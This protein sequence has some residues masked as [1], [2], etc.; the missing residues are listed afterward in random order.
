MSTIQVDG[1]RIVSATGPV[2]N[3]V[4]LSVAAGQSWAITGRSGSGK[5]TLGLAILGHVRPGLT[6][7]GGA[8]SIGT[9][10]V[11]PR[12]RR[13]RPTT[14]GYVGQDPGS[15]LNPYRRVGTTLRSAIR[16][17]RGRPSTVEQLLARVGL[18]AEFAVRYP[19]QLSGGQQQR[20]ALAVA[21]ASEPAV[22]V[23]DEPT[24]ALDAESADEVRRELLRARANGT[25]LSPMTSMSS[26][27]SS[28]T[29]PCSTRV[30]SPAEPRAGPRLPA[31]RQR[32][33]PAGPTLRSRPCAPATSADPR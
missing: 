8:V 15:A 9:Y 21:L 10:A 32:P 19:H 2:L 11:L 27:A 14:A 30:R 5:T 29:S 7:A 18:P 3:D 28:T 24:S 25:Q 33:R 23:L 26:T 4:T 16:Q 13:S 6:H 20:V 31:A 1:L 17:V 22:V 12:P